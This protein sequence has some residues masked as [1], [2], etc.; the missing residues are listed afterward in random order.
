MYELLVFDNHQVFAERCESCEELYIR[1]HDI[2]T[3][4][5]KYTGRTCEKKKCDGKL[6][7]VLLDW[8]VDS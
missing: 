5:F 7:D 4:G 8:F 3:I 1:S 6:K 2:G